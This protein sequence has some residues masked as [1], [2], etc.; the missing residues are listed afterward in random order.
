[1]TGRPMIGLMLWLLA[2]VP[3][4]AE[5]GGPTIPMGSYRMVLAQPDGG[6][7]VGLE[8]TR[9]RGQLVA[10]LVN[11]AGRIRAEQAAMSGTTLTLAFPSYASSLSAQL[12]PDGTLAGTARLMRQQGP[13]EVPF[14]ARRGEAF[15]FFS[16][17]AGQPMAV[18]GTW[19][20]TWTSPDGTRRAGVGLLRQKGR[21]VEGTFLFTTGDFRF[22]AGEVN[23]T[24]LAL[25]TFDGNQGS[26]WRASRQR[27]G[28]LSGTLIT[29][30]S[31]ADPAS[32]GRWTARLDP[33]A[34]L[35]DPTR[36]TVLQPGYDRFAFAFPDV[37]GQMVSLDDPRF[38][39]RV[40]IVTIGGTWCPNCH[41]EA[42]F[43]QPLYLKHRRRGLEVVGLQF[44]YTDDFARSA[45]Q[46]RRF[47]A[48]FGLTY[49]LLIAGR[50]GRDTTRAALPAIGGVSTYPTMIV[51]DRRGVVRRIHTGFSGPA[52]GAR[53]TDFAREFER[54][55]QGL[56]AEKA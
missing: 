47:A 33:K 17:P 39:G 36:I 26:V 21:V 56:L 29:P 44:E 34:A 12:R 48:R 14:T 49:P 15:R 18:N 41:D 27:D 19:A 3:A 52:T 30:T 16:A 46:A 55:V 8:L 2:L 11:G 51:I 1:M 4:W 45:A 42:A 54:F 37:D 13:V 28:T 50:V 43:L 24:E 35:D 22:L 7:P 23:G 32:W 5:T 40:V 9:A 53:Y 25:S 6:L 20:V 38:R 31:T 10:T